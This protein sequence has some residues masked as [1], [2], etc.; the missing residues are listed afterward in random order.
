MQKLQSRLSVLRPEDEKTV[1]AFTFTGLMGKKDGLFDNMLG[2]AHIKNGL[3]EINLNGENQIINKEQV[4]AVNPDIIFVPTWNYNNENDING[5]AQSILNDPAYQNIKAVKN[6]RLEFVSDRY[7]NV[8]SQHITEAV[9]VMA[10][11]VY[12]EIFK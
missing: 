12:P 10:K 8:A 11:A 7:R 1:L 2:L 3:A 5:Y 9:E 4:I 6:K